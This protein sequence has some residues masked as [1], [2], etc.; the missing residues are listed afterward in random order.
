MTGNGE[1][2]D[3]ICSNGSSFWECRAYQRT[4]KR[5]DGANKLCSELCLMIQERAELEKAYSSNLKKWSA[6]WL[7][8]LDSGLE[9]GTG[10]CPWRGLCKEAEAISNIHLNVR[11]ILLDEI[12]TGLKHW[13]K[14]HFHK[15]SLPPQ[16][17]KETKQFDQD[18]ELAQKLWAKRLKR[19]HCTKKEYYQACK[20][21]RSLQVQVQNAKN[22]PSGTAEQL[23]KIQEKLAK[24]EKDVQRTRNAYKLAIA[25]LDTES[26]RY[27][28]EMTKVF[29]RTQDFERER[30]CFFKET[31]NNL[32]NAL[33]VCAKADYDSIYNELAHSISQ[34]DI[35]SDLQWWSVNHGVDMPF[36]F[37]RFEEYSPELAAMS[38]KKRGTIIDH[39]LPVTLTNVTTISSPVDRHSTVTSTNN[40]E[41]N[42]VRLDNGVI[43]S[44]N[45][46]Q[47]VIH[48]PFDDKASK[49][50]T[51][52]P[53]T[54]SADGDGNDEVVSSGA[55]DSE[56][57][58]ATYDDGRPGVKVRALYDYVGQEDDE[59]SFVAGD[60]FDKLE[61]ADDQGWCKGRKDGRAGLYPANYVEVLHKE[62]P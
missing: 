21:E 43:S 54:T 13:Q 39:G 50:S 18:F 7:S 11:N 29:T 45:G 60:V 24:A 52:P 12:Q 61:E 57:N 6:R 35:E 51:P 26:A 53:T 36:V 16:N 38:H 40:S 37:P 20:T 9:Y 10:S 34:C 14:E 41:H 8:F 59:I 44:P 48:T 42:D 56:V 4:V 49:M 46:P 32:H 25:E 22:D 31:F 33:N 5:V 19:A 3:Q 28:E 15:S 23:K 30:L 58:D 27:V 1:F 62:D 2:E 17:L 55:C 47:S